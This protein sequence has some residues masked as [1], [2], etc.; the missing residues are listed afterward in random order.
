MSGIPRTLPSRT[1][2]GQIAAKDVFRIALESLS[3]MDQ[4]RRKAANMVWGKIEHE[5]C[6]HLFG[7][8]KH[9]RWA[10]RRIAEERSHAMLTAMNIGWGDYETC[11]RLRDFARFLLE[12]NPDAMMTISTEDFR[13]LT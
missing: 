8:Y 3:A 7:L 13:A 6:S 10:S 4:T 1:S 2:T 12:L 9:K 5:Q 11:E